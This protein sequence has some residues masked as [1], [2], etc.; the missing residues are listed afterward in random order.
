MFQS[1]LVLTTRFVQ[2]GHTKFYPPHKVSA[3]LKTR[4]GWVGWSVK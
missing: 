4:I 3:Y 2:G 1:L